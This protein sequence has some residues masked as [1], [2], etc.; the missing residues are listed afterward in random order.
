MHYFIGFLSKPYNF[1]KIVIVE[2]KFKADN[3]I[4]NPL[5]VFVLSSLSEQVQST[6]ENSDECSNMKQSIREESSG[7]PNEGL[8][9]DRTV[10]SRLMDDVAATRIQNAFR[11]FMVQYLCRAYSALCSSQFSL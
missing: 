10:P 1:K 9:M 8:M 4:C 2:E 3:L 7:I 5:P 11:S 6:D